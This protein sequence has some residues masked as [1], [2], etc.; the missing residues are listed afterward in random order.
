MTDGAAELFKSLSTFSRIN[1]LIEMGESEGLHLECKSPQQPRLTKGT[2]V[3]LAKAI[4]GFSNTAGGLVIYGIGT[5]KHTHSGLDVLSQIESLANCKTYEQQV[6]RAIPTLT[7]PSILS[8]QTSHILEKKDDKRGVVIVYIP[9]NNGDPVQS[10]K[11]DLFYLRTGDE[12]SVAPHEVIKKLFSANESPDLFP[13]FLGGLVKTEADGTWKI[14]I[15]VGNSSSA[16]ADNVTVSVTI[17]NP[18]ACSAI[19]SEGFNDTSSINP[20]RSIF[21]ANFNRVIHRGLNMMAGS[22]RVQMKVGKRPK[23][24]LDLSVSLYA[25]NMRAKQ[26][27]FSI[28]LAKSG[29]DVA[30]ISQKYLY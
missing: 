13:V 24:R 7:T 19:N 11:D 20:G 4:S 17:K 27:E 23:R 10:V 26:Y 2:I 3:H 30:L 12:F 9:G 8:F 16:V 6:K 14:P 29:F 18:S 21:M 5:T 25:N 1:E 15:V 28:K 22:L